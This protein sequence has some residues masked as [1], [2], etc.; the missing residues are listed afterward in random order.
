[1]RSGRPALRRRRRR[2]DGRRRRGSAGR[3][4]MP[5]PKASYSG[6]NV[7]SLVMCALLLMFSGMFMY[8]LLRNMWSWNGPYSVNSSLMDMVLSWF[9][10]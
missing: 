8:D 4:R 3:R 7:A 2:V 9:E 10:K 6:W 1:M 5:R